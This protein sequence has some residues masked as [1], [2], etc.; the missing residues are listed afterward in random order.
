MQR[1]RGTVWMIAML[2]AL[3]A[4]AC[5]PDYPA[6]DD[7]DDC[8]ENE[9]CVDNQCQQC[10]DDSHCAP[11]QTCVGGRCEDI[12]GYC[13]GAGDCPDGQECRNNR[14]VAQQMTD[15][16]D[17]DTDTGS[18]ACELQVVYFAFDSE[19]LDSS[20]RNTISAN[21]R[22]IRDRGMGAVHVTGY[23]DPRG[24]EEYNLALGDRRARS[25][26][27]YMT[28]LG[29]ENITAS[30]MGEE[31]STGEDEAGYRF[32]RKVTFTQR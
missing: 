5:G 8:H 13:N 23:T 20:A 24:T 29:A 12:E 9:Y 19:E 30:S 14:C 15:L 17:T 6:C 18:G 11:G 7:D 27:Q 22:C 1:G 21:V 10:R 32:D 25:V 16:G 26:Q 4:L 31:M 3:S 28:S 2:G